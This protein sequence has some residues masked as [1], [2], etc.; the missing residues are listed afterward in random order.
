VPTLTDLVWLAMMVAMM[1]LATAFA[2]WRTRQ[3]GDGRADPIISPDWTS[4]E[5]PASPPSAVRWGLGAQPEIEDDHVGRPFPSS[6]EPY[7]IGDLSR[8]HRRPET[9]R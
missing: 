2:V 4:I 5:R 7:R 8:D 1:G 9:S 3:I 6:A